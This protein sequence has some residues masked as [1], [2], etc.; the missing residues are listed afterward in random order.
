MVSL[1]GIWTAVR[2]KMRM[3]QGKKARFTSLTMYRV[4]RCLTLRRILNC[5]RKK[6]R[7]AN[8]LAVKSMIIQLTL[9]NYLF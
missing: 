3:Y 9:Q 5:Y 1:F 4:G 6:T 2:K 7:V 8:I